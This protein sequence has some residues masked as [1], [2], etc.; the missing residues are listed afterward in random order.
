MS[1]YMKR[2]DYCEENCGKENREGYKT[3]KNCGMLNVPSADVQPV[4]Q[5]ISVDDRLPESEKEVLVW[6]RY[7]WGAA[8]TSY[9]FGINVWNSNIKR[10]REGCLLKGVEVL[11]WQPL[12]EPPKDGDTE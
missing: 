11:Y 5:W 9:G 10:W 8:S 4:K 1:E 6:Y 2:E 12:P 7:T 3:C